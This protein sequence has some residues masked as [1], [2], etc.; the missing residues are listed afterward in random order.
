MNI[1]TASARGRLLRQVLV[2]ALVAGASGDAWS[3]AA[4]V[5]PEECLKA[6]PLEDV[7]VTAV[8]L[9][10]KS[11]VAADAKPVHAPA[12][13]GGTEPVKVRLRDE[14]VVHVQ[15]LQTLLARALCTDPDRNIVLYLD[16]RPIYNLT[17]F[18]PSNPADGTLLFTLSASPPA[19]FRELKDRSEWTHFLGKPRWDA[20]P[21]NVSVG[22]A[23]EHAAR[24]E[25][26]VNLEVI[27]RGRFL[28]WLIIFAGLVAGFVALAHKSELLRDPG[29]PPQGGGGKP[30]S[31]ARMQAAWWFFLALAA[32]LFIWI[33]TGNY[34][35]TLT[36]TVLTLLG[37]SAATVLGSTLIGPAKPAPAAPDAALAPPNAAAA[38]AA[39]NVAAAPAPARRDWWFTEILSDAQGVS[40]H[41]FQMAVWTAVLGIIFIT[42]VYENLAMP[43]FDATLLGL[44]GISAGTYLG[45]KTQESAPPGA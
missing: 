32:Y 9:R 12:V 23:D 28:L 18:P 7:K 43:T 19:G 42:E 14:I 26:R 29:P 34:S 2:W 39:P 16:G 20:R 36:G 8:E 4:A 15:N 35:T 38:A 17:P 22:L 31:L 1:D 24:S 44:L 21:T 27:P 30:Y 3:Q 13:K 5:K 40:F 45:L 37:I 11:Q 33:I 25:A 41:R 10:P 6:H